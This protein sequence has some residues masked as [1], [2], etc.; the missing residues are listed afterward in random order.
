MY[1]PIFAYFYLRTKNYSTFRHKDIRKF[2]FEPG[3][4]VISSSD[5]FTCYCS[6]PKKKTSG[7][8]APTKTNVAGRKRP[9]EATNT[10]SSDEP[11]VRKFKI[12]EISPKSKFWLFFI[13]K[14]VMLQRRIHRGRRIFYGERAI[15][16]MV[17]WFSQK[18]LRSLCIRFCV[19]YCIYCQYMSFCVI[20]EIYRAENDLFF[21]FI[22]LLDNLYLD[23]IVV[24]FPIKTHFIL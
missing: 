4:V 22:Y 18:I 13:Y 20:I 10:T 8:Q 21:T 1:M 9:S 17:H 12:S 14:I 23:S 11:P 2:V 3:N 16:F 15:S 6:W 24:A 19:V 5:K 7:F